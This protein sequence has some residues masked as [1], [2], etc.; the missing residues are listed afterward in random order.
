MKESGQM[1]RMWLKWQPLT[2]KGCANAVAEG[3]SLTNVLS[4]FAALATLAGFALLFLL[5]EV[6]IAK[7]KKRSPISTSK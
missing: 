4:A 1:D 2:Q 5:L 7:L 3:L 6:I